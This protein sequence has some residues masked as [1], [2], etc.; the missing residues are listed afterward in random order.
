MGHLTFLSCLR[1]VIA[2]NAI[3]FGGLLSLPAT[4]AQSETPSPQSAYLSEARAGVETVTTEQLRAALTS[5]TPPLLLDVR[6]F[7]EREQGKTITENEIHIPRGFLEF[8]AWAQLPQDREIVV[9]C[10]T[11]GRSALAVQTLKAMGWTEVKSLEGGI[12]EFY[13]SQGEDCG[14][15]E[16]PFQ[17]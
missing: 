10:A 12:T 2:L 16:L 3:L 6:T 15:I 5:S 11:G 17:E 4:A 13:Q 14:C 1:G 8:K 7:T 9:Y